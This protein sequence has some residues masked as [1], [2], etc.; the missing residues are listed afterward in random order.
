MEKAD[1]VFLWARIALQDLINGVLAK[2]TLKMLKDRLEYLNGSLD[3]IFAQLLERVHPVHQASAANYLLFERMWYS[4]FGIDSFKAELTVLDVAFACDLDLKQDIQNLILSNPQ[5]C[6]SQDTVNAL[7][8]RLNDFGPLLR[9]RCAGLLD[10]NTACQE[11]VFR[12]DE[13]WMGFNDV[14]RELPLCPLARHCYHFQVC[15]LKLHS[16]LDTIYCQ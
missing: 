4:R 1:G 13:P 12:A 7:V 14:D 2:D 9:N 15:Y 6:G 10:V 16:S 3:G 8:Q 5:D 11:P